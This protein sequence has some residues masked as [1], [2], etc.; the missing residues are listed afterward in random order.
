MTV[1]VFAQQQAQGIGYQQQG[2][3]SGTKLCVQD[4]SD[5]QWRG[6]REGLGRVAA[7]MAA[8]AAASRAVRLA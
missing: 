1:T 4:L 6:F 5:I 2:H 8:Y 7:A 3:L